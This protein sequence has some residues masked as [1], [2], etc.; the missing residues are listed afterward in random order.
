MIV[1]V[2][3]GSESEKSSVGAELAQL[4]SADFMEGDD[5]QPGTN[6][7]KMR[8]GIPLSDEDRWPWL[9]KLAAATEAWVAN[10][11]DIVVSCQALKKSYR[12]LLKGNNDN[13]HLVYL[14]GAGDMIYKRI[15][16]DSNNSAPTGLIEGHFAELEEDED[17]IVVEVKDNPAATAAEVKQRLADQV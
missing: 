6:I 11:R 4:L 14:K 12:E 9:K 2:M 8:S 16:K 7:V 1:V 10:G 15:E 17:A 5:F 13:F 3:G